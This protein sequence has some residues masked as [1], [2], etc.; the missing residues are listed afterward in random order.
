SVV[1]LFITL[2]LPVR[3]AKDLGVPLQRLQKGVIPTRGD[4]K[5]RACMEVRH[6]IDLLVKVQVV[7]RDASQ[8]PIRPG[9]ARFR[10]EH[11][12]EYDVFMCPG[13]FQ[14]ALDQWFSSLAAACRGH[15]PD[16]TVIEAAAFTGL[17]YHVLRHAFY[18]VPGMN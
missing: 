6:L 8:V 17:F 7:P 11:D 18:D 16:V 15:N 9:E 10:T 4:H 5:I 2:V 12:I 3:K 1:V 14:T 13:E